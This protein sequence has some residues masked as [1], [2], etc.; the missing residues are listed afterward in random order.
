LAGTQKESRE[1]YC[2]MVDRLETLSALLLIASNFT[3]QDIFVGNKLCFK[4][5]V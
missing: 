4:H 3:K 2:R 5:T 1:K